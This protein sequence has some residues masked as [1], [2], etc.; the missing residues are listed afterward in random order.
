MRDESLLLSGRPWVRIPPGAPKPPKN[1]RFRAKKLLTA[2]R[3]GIGGFSILG[4]QRSRCPCSYF[5]RVISRFLIFR[6]DFYDRFW[7]WAESTKISRISSLTDFASSAEVVEIANELLQRRRLIFLH[8]ESVI[9]TA[10]ENAQPIRWSFSK[11]LLIKLFIFGIVLW[12]LILQT[13][14]RIRAFSMKQ[15]DL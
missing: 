13:I 8:S 15:F 14:V 12:R 5:Q 7:D 1:P 10:C 2:L 11:L 6:P 9:C 4:C 3:S